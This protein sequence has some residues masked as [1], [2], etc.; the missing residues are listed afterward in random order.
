MD[1]ELPPQVYFNELN[2]DS[3]NIL[4]LYWYHPPEYW[5]YLAHAQKVNLE[6][7]KRFEDEGI[8]FAFPTQTLYLAGDPNRDLVVKG[9][10]KGM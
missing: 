6:L 2:A 9:L 7:M 5:D 10:E 8:E 1:P 4:A 3:L